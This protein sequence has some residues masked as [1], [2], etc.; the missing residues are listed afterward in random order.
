MKLLC[1][2]LEELCIYEGSLFFP[3]ERSAQATALKK[4]DLYNVHTTATQLAAV[5]AGLTSLTSLM[6]SGCQDP[7]EGREPSDE[8]PPLPQSVPGLRYTA[9]PQK[10]QMF[11]GFTL[12]RHNAS[13]SSDVI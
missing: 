2:A 9:A 10:M 1:R 12:W 11:E 5:C 13:Q 7:D 3:L 6:V 4:L 8:F